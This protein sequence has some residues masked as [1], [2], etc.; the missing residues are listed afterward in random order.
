[1]DQI[2]IG[3]FIKRTR[4]N[5][6]I[7]QKELSECLNISDR[8]ISKW[9]N[10]KCMPDCSLI[11]ELC[12]LLNITI[13]DLFSGEIIDMNNNEKKL[14]ENLLEMTKL[15]QE[16]DK[17]LL[18][19]EIFIVFLSIVL[20]FACIFISEYMIMNRY[21][22]VIVIVV[23][24]IICLIGCALGLRIEQTA[25]YYKC[26]KCAHKYTPTYISVLWAMHI[27]RTRY[28]KCPKCKKYTW[29]KKVISKE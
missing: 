21:F 8:A 14:E 29:S 1:M 28:L 25:G 19:L 20:L 11:P 5:R 2:K 4:L 3:K 27:G 6:N 16:R 23:G 15:K 9:E 17:Q 10:G 22:K 13:N 18:E 7:T 24:F 26:G 12:E